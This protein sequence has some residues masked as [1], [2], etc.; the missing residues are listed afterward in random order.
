MLFREPRKGSGYK[1]RL[2][3][4]LTGNSQ[5]SVV[6]VAGELVADTRVPMLIIPDD[7][8][9]CAEAPLPKNDI[10]FVQEGIEAKIKLHIFPSSNKV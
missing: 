4:L 1:P 10:G 5:D 7:G 9:L 8:C 3:P 2:D 6:S